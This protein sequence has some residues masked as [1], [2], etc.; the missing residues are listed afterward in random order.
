MAIINTLRSLF[1]PLVWKC[2]GNAFQQWLIGR[3]AS[4]QGD[5][6]KLVRVEV[7]LD[8]NQAMQPVSIGPEGMPQKR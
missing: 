3:F 8:A 5:D 7:D 4:S 6:V 2:V 1:E